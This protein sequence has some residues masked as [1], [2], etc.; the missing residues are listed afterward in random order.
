[1]KKPVSKPI[2]SLTVRRFLAA[3]CLVC[4]PASVATSAE[5]VWIA[6]TLAGTGTAGGNGDGGRA[7]QAQFNNPFGV[8][9]GPDEAL[10]IAEYDGHRIRRIAP[11]GIVSTVAGTGTKGDSG[12][13][14]P[15]IEAALN[16]P[17]EVRFDSLG[18]LYFTDM[19]NHRIRRVHKDTGIIETIAG[20]GSAG[21]SGDG[22]PANQAQ[23]NKPHSIQFDK[24]DH[25][26]I[27]DIGN[28]RVRVIH[29]DS[30]IIT[31]LAGT[32]ERKP[33]PDGVPFIGVP[34]NGP[35]TLDFDAHGHL[36]LA[37]REGN[38]VFKLNLD[39]GT[40]HHIA[41]T[42]AK[43]FSGNNGPAI[44]A[45][46]SGPKGLAIS[47]DGMN[48]FL[49]DTESHSIRMIDLQTGLLHLICGTGT[50]GSGPDGPALQCRLARPHGIFVD[51]DG[52]LLVGDSESHV[53]RR[54]FVRKSP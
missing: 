15:A 3:F 28:Q 11:D 34:L 35:R 50:T 46:L 8:V 22:G 36:W 40:I 39:A 14:G 18:H 4:L 48:I 42:G 7:L 33:T 10:Y 54:L 31:T 43:G 13:G 49:V 6:E 45:T 27:C 37:L 1:M 30:G 25:L 20:T 29:P 44:E 9:R 16:L 32:G 51:S 47:H 5:S 19:A 23:L 12:D 2:F 52:S 21:F 38:Q 24:N 41:G 17:H 26:Y 53:I